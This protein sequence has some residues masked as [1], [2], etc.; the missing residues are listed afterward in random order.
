VR[1]VF[2]ARVPDVVKLLSNEF[3]RLILV[4]NLIAWPFAYFVTNSWLQNFS[5][6]TDVNWTLYLFAGLIT[7]II[8]LIITA[9]IAITLYLFAGLIT[10]I[11]SLI[12]TASI[13]ISA[14]SRNPADI[15]RQE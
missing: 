8:S 12:I 3:I 14:S 6:K 11:I 7:L 15:I 4:A 9:S 5:Q 10:L 13:A 2:G 1:R